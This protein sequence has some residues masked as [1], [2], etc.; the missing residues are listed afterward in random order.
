MSYAWIKLDAN[1]CVDE[2]LENDTIEEAQ[3]R[4]GEA[5]LIK[6]I[7]NMPFLKGWFWNGERFEER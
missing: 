7:N 4:A 5:Q 3:E 6:H 2:V 1:N